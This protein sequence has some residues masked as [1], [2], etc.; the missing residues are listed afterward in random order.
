MVINRFKTDPNYRLDT[1]TRHFLPCLMQLR[2][3]SE[4]D[5]V[6]IG[7]IQRVWCSLLDK[8]EGKDKLEEE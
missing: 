3:S 1:M 6:Y 5:K 4:E 2:L 7:E 8:L